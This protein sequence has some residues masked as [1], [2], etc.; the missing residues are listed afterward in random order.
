MQG[1]SC[2]HDITTSAKPAKPP[3]TAR[4]P[5]IVSQKPGIARRR[6]KISRP[7][8]C[9]N[10]TTPTTQTTRKKCFDSLDWLRGTLEKFKNQTDPLLKNTQPFPCSKQNKT[11]QHQETQGFPLQLPKVSC[12]ESKANLFM[13]L[14]PKRPSGDCHPSVVRFK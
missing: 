11:M 7:W 9:K 3:R 12:A 6:E 5:S 8:I 2:L 13:A 4:A 1:V 10:R 14:G